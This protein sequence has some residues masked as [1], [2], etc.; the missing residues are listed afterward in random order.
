MRR[1]KQQLTNE[2][3]IEILRT[4]TSGVFAVSGDCGYPYAVPMSY[5]FSDGKIYFHCAKS[6]HKLD[7]VKRDN[8]ASFCVIHK[9]DV[10]PEE[11]TT[12]YKSVIVFGKVRI[13]DSGEE[14]V[15]AARILGKKYYPEVTENILDEEIT[16]F[17]DNML[18]LVLE[19]E[20]I[21]GKCAKELISK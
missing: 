14:M 13:I 9:D 16:K 18:I 15:N 2:E 6:G 5:V 11:F 1:S 10:V 19:A 7:G 3:A 17:K 12:Y 4:E 21:T 8:K 20:H